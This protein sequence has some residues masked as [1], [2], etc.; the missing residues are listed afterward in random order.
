MKHSEDNTTFIHKIANKAD[1]RPIS[2]FMRTVATIDPSSNLCAAVSLM[3]HS[4]L[5]AVLVT[6]GSDVL[7][8]LDEKQAQ[9]ALLSMPNSFEAVCAAQFPVLSVSS[10][11]FPSVNENV[12]I[13]QALDIM[14]QCQ[15]EYLAVVDAENKI[16]G[17]VLRRDVLAFLCDALRPPS[18]GG[19]ATPLGVYLT[20]G[21]IRAGAC[22][23]G[24]FLSGAS[25]MLLNIAAMFVV[26]FF[27]KQVDLLFE[28]NVIG[29]LSSPPIPL[30]NTYDF[31]HYIV[32]VVHILL[33]LLFL[34]L[35]PLAQYHAAE[36]QVVNAIEQ[37]QP[38]NFESVSK[39]SRVHT[40]CGTNIGAAVIIFLVITQRFTGP[41]AFVLSLVVVLMSWRLLGGWLQAVFTTRKP[42]AKHLESGILAAEEL[43]AKYQSNLGLR[44]TFKIKVWNTGILQV[45]A[46]V[47]AV[48]I[49]M[50]LITSAFGFSLPL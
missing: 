31:P 2:H 3:R 19:M 33:F 37:R 18:P 49:V 14:N 12:T 30:P 26:W 13:R 28:L 16:K 29:S 22:D 21:P 34:H 42:E 15:S 17:L 32:V 24:L 6:D 23:W 5:P 8:V 48:N 36:H 10:A 44:P 9:S 46:G 1:D 43:I 11:D 40:R 4:G 25:M 38:L 35:S 50:Y 20:S 27:A 39:M 47:L 45:L 7:G 41:I